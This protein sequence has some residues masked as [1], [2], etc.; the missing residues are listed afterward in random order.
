MDNPLAMAAEPVEPA[1]PKVMN[2]EMLA[3]YDKLKSAGETLSSVRVGLD[4]LTALADTL[5]Q[6]DVIREASVLVAKGLDAKSVAGLLADMP[7][8][9]EQLAEWVKGHSE[10]VK[11]REQQLAQ[12]TGQVQHK[13]ATGAMRGLMAEEMMGKHDAGL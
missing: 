3:Q 5:T 6:E 12:V 1:E 7:E 2:T 9:P 10:Q 4:K 13:L 11:Q 8:H